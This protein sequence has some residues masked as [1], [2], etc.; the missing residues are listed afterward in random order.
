[1]ELVICITHIISELQLNILD[2]TDYELIRL[3]SIGDLI[4][5][6]ASKKCL[7]HQNEN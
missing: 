6:L 2:F 1:M 7:T 3:K 5:L 4:D